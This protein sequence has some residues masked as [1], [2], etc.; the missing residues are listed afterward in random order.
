MIAVDF[1]CGAGGL[2]R[3]LMRAGCRVLVGIDNDAECEKTYNFNN[4]PAQF[5]HGDLRTMDPKVLRPYLR[6]VPK[7]KLLLVG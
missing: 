1:F 7:D 6:G 3:G 2:T 5:M 4:K